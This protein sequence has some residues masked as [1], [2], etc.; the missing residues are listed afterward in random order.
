M[1]RLILLPLIC[2]PLLLAPMGA[3]GKEA[4]KEGNQEQILY[5]DLETFANILTLIQQYYVDPVDANKVITGAINGMMATLDP[6]SAYMS[7]ED[8]KEL[9]EETTGSFTGIGIEISI[10]DGQLTAVAPIEGTPADRKNIQPGDQILR[11]DGAPTKD[12]TLLE[13]TK[14]L[15]GPK[16]STVTITVI[17]K[18]WATPRDI[19][20]V[21]EAIPLASVKVMEL[22][23]GYACVRISSFQTATAAD[24]KKAIQNLRQKG[25]IRGMILDLRNNPGGLLDQAIKVTDL[26]L[27]RGVIVS[28]RGRNKEEHIT[29]RAHEEDGAYTFPLAILV[30]SGSASGSEIVA[31]ALQD[32]K[33]AIIIGTTTF[34]KGSVQ[35]VLPLLDGSGLR[36]TTAK[37][38]TPSGDSIQARGIR[39]NMV[40]ALK[41]SAT[42]VKTAGA[43][44]REKDLPQ[45]LL[46]ETEESGPSVAGTEAGEE[47]Q[48]ETFQEVN[49]IKQVGLRLAQD[50]QLRTALLVLKS[51]TPKENKP[52]KTNTA[53][54]R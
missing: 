30:N 8:F 3:V 28:T 39:P 51:Q 17:R 18:G 16:G 41:S 49:D 54:A 44:I 2:L 11:I 31:G 14:K 19:A 48:K 5:R 22:E 46:N 21:R 38:Y 25:P 47:D 50:N 26:F 20:L 52:P 35:T 36:L 23:P 10:R 13:A 6:H 7:P 24:V 45:H 27:D 15:R 34:G 40:V 4:G 1:K 37:Y 9:E 33:R 42:A 32:H 43:P 53:G 12:M 29:F